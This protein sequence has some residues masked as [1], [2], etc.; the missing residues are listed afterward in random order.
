MN[1]ADIAYSDVEDEQ[2]LSH[3]SK[4]TKE[5]RVEMRGET[6]KC[7]FMKTNMKSCVRHIKIKLLK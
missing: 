7:E 6:K 2:Y 3:F 1:S 5:N 4:E